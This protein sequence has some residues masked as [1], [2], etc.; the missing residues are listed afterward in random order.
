MSLPE[1]EPRDEGGELSRCPECEQISVAERALDAEILE[2]RCQNPDCGHRHEF[3]REAAE[4]LSA[5]AS[6]P[7]GP[8]RLNRTATVHDSGGTQRAEPPRPLHRELP[9]ADP[10]PVDALGETLGPAARAIQEK[11][12]SPDSI[13]AES[14]LATA[15]L[16]VQ[17]FANVELPTGAIRP[18]SNF[19]VAVASSGERKTSADQCAT[20]P[21]RDREA[22]LAS[23]YAQDREFFEMDLAA[24]EQQ[25]RQV[26]N[27]KGTTRAAKREALEEVGPRPNE[28]LLPLL[29]CPEPTFEGLT[30]LFASGWPSLGVFSSEGG[31]FIGGHGM[32][33]DNRLKT[34]A[35]LSGLW[36][37]EPL[38]R[39]RAG[40]PVATLRGR[41]L[42]VHLL[43]QPGIAA[44]LLSDPLLADQGL[45]S[46]LLVAA[47]E[48]T[49]GTRFW[50]NPTH[51]AERNLRRYHERLS[52][53]LSRPLPLVEGT[54]NELN[55]RTLRFSRLARDLWI[56]F[57]DH[58]ER[59]MGP[60]G[61]YES[62]RG[63][64]NKLPEH[65]TRLAGVV[66]LFD[67]LELEELSEQD[68]ARGIELAKFYASEA[69]RLFEAGA[70][71][72]DL[73][74]ADHLLQWLQASWP[75]ELVSLPDIYQRGPNGI[76]DQKRAR[77]MV[78]ILE[79]HG[80]LV[81]V[82]GGAAVAGTKRRDVWRIV[83]P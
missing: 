82:R 51:G 71:D 66:A 78:Q 72:P 26:L 5:L 32:N 29:T 24:W 74:L 46:R 49:V 12:Q 59:Q 10:F 23:A 20:A 39:V 3:S 53:I 67:D 30:K 73:A 76:R 27:K 40:D 17:G 52:S 16:A 50:R 64:A 21:V 44:G 58:V 14:V 13:C 15:S 60:G 77:A 7:D 83:A 8:V 70:L 45:L 4:V 2:H 48:S 54:R 80:W 43:V 36:D 56:R 63:L 81:P 19:F 57:A 28:P 35:A 18:L 38:K 65:A 62:I 61:D 55:P 37:G 25:R 34:A 75:E 68:L 6:Q 11:T 1:H 9:P 33:Q 42:T 47:P 69:L 41:R 22:S 79:E 31:Q